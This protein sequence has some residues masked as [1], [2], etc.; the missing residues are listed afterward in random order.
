MQ[1]PPIRNVIALLT[2]QC[3]CACPYCFE[4]RSPERMSL[5]VAKDILDFVKTGGGKSSGFTFF[6]GE[7]MLEFESIMVPLVEYSEQSPIPTRFAMT[8][9]GTLLDEDRL[10]WLAKHMRNICGRTIS[11]NKK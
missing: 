2:N 7:P 8:T 1:F 4:A 10:A 3:Q 5:N 11:W 6:G 9:N